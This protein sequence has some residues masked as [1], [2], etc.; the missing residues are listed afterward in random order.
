MSDQKDTTSAQNTNQGN[1]SERQR[2]DAS[3]NDTYKRSVTGYDA[4]KQ[5]EDFDGTM[6]STGGNTIDER[7]TNDGDAN[8]ENNS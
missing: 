8:N 6:K 4:T 2:Q 3:D 7:E 1:Q 5:D